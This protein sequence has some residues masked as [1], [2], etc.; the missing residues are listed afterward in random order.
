MKHAQARQRAIDLGQRRAGPRAA[1]PGETRPRL[2]RDTSPLARRRSAPRVWLKLDHQVGE[3]HAPGTRARRTPAPWA[4]MKR[5]RSCSW[6]PR[7]ASATIAAPL[8]A[9][10]Q[11]GTAAADRLAAAHGSSA[12]PYCSTQRC[13]AGRA[14][15]EFSVEST[16]SK[17]DRPSRSGQTEPCRHRGARG[18]A[19]GP[20]PDVDERSC[21][22][23]RS[24]GG[25]SWSRRR[26]SAAR[27]SEIAIA[28]TAVPAPARASRPVTRPTFTPAMRHRGVAV[29]ARLAD[30]NHAVARRSRG[31]TAGALVNPRVDAPHRS[32]SRRDQAGGERG[33]SA[34][35]SHRPTPWGGPV[36]SVEPACLAGHV[37]RSAGRAGRAR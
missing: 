4:A 18:A 20:G 35:A 5:L 28:T 14:L 11:F 21:P 9:P 33:D 13:A 23:G 29:A 1:F 8:K 25:P 10:V 2:A 27:A 15:L 31:A 32:A 7:L 24:A 3:L 30:A 12:A 17:L 26:G 19:P 22:R 6:V 34:R 37:C 16:W 36:S